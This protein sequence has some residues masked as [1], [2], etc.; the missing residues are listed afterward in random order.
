M[1][2][3]TPSALINLIISWA[4]SWLLLLWFDNRFQY[5]WRW[6][7]L[8]FFKVCNAITP[9]V[10]VS[11]WLHLLEM[12]FLNANESAENISQRCCNG[13]LSS[14]CLHLWYFCIF[15]SIFLP[16]VVCSHNETYRN[17]CHLSDCILLLSRSCSQKI[18]FD[19]SSRVLT[20]TSIDE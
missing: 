20:R 19:L 10:T 17:I 2:P 9:W 1:I 14:R 11:S 16:S 4:R 7:I 15:R 3:S 6:T 18:K 13:Q 12:I 8:L 5:M